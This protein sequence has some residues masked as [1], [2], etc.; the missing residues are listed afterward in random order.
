MISFT[1]LLESLKQ[2]DNQ[3]WQADIPETWMQGRTTYGGLSAALCLQAAQQQ[4]DNLPPLRSAQISFIGPTSG[5]V[6][7][8]VT[9]LRQGKSVSFICAELL[10]DKQIATHAVFCFGAHRDSQLNSNFIETPQVP[11]YQELPANMFAG[12]A[13]APKFTENF[14]ARF[15]KG[16]LPMSGAERGEFFIWAKHNC[17][18]Q[19][20]AGL[21]GIADMLPPAVFPMFKQPAPLS[22]MTWIVNIVAENIATD[23]GW[24]LLNSAAEQVQNGYSS[25][26]MK[27]WNSSGEIILTG[28]QSVAVFY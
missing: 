26:E 25:Q 5:T 4:F 23:D 22:S 1:Q 10:S 20:M 2:A 24:W 8:K 17:A 19:R 13:M 18:N 9:E 16:E 28:K 7:I 27:L 11:S 21:L 15:A 3:N 6:E 12:S 14:D